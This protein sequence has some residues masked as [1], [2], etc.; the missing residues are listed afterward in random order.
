MKKNQ[1]DL[2]NKVMWTPDSKTPNGV[3]E[4]PLGLTDLAVEALGDQVQLA[5]NTAYLFPARTPLVIRRRSR[6]RGGSRFIER[7][8]RPSASTTCAQRMR[9]A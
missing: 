6:R 5:G 3:A 2:E 4:A 8:C 1:V 7:R 9:R